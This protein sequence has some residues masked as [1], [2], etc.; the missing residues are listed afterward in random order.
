[1]TKLSKA[2]PSVLPGQAEAAQPGDVGDAPPVGDAAA[3]GEHIRDVNPGVVGNTG[4]PDDDVEAAAVGEPDGPPVGVDQEGPEPDA[5][6]PQSPVGSDD[7][8]PPGRASGDRAGI[9]RL[10]PQAE[11]DEPPQ[12]VP[13]QEPLGQ[14]RRVPTD[15]STGR[16]AA[17]SAAISNPALPPPTTGTAP[18]V[19]VCRLA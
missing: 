3:V 7:P 17:S 2:E 5:G 13:A 14:H 4:G 18:S 8:F 16:V 6:P 1:L 19:R 12:Q 10:S 9:G 15:T 11:P